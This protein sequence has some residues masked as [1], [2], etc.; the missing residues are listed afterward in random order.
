MNPP[1]RQNLY[2]AVAL[3]GIMLTIAVL[4][5]GEI[6][7]KL[8][9]RSSNSVTRS[10]SETAETRQTTSRASFATGSYEELGIVSEFQATEEEFLH[11][12]CKGPQIYEDWIEA[13]QMRLP[14]NYLYRGGP[15]KLWE[16]PPKKITGPETLRAKHEDCE[17][18]LPNTHAFVLF[19]A[20][21]SNP[22]H[23]IAEFIRPMM[24]M[25]SICLKDHPKHHSEE[26]YVLA[27]MEGLKTP[28]WH[29]TIFSSLLTW[30]AGSY[31]RVWVAAS[32]KDAGKWQFL[33][34]SLVP[35]T[36]AN[37]ESSK[38][39]FAEHSFLRS[40]TNGPWSMHGVPKSLRNLK[41][42]TTGT[43]WPFTVPLERTATRNMKILES[44]AE[45]VKQLGDTKDSP[46]ETFISRYLPLKS[47]TARVGTSV[48]QAL[49]QSMPTR[50]NEAPQE[51]TSIEALGEAVRARM[52]RENRKL[53]V[54]IY[55]RADEPTAKLP[56]AWVNAD[57]TVSALNKIPSAHDLMEIDHIHTMPIAP[58]EQAEKYTA[59]VLICPHG[60]HLGNLIFSSNTLL[61]EGV[62]SQNFSG[63]RWYYW[64]RI[65]LGH[66]IHPV[67]MLHVNGQGSG[68]TVDPA[69]VI[70]PLSAL[71]NVDTH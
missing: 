49:F 27:V 40:K 31:D 29:R 4:R 52:Q 50:Y 26:F 16:P 41:R 32:D 44:H 7:S 37:G 35:R 5:E 2:A 14:N 28:S 55:D 9:A 22:V 17:D 21:Q 11:S 33:N 39:C 51:W 46:E 69:L 38:Q 1:I 47:A 66:L 65:A 71:L 60:G 3:A 25:A 20:R 57:E 12:F 42:D 15:L 45:R 23:L 19:F 43:R 54:L 10:K 62:P 18:V 30:I 70:A 68:L 67:K 61:I 24:T 53:R 6:H 63:Q 36:Q 48:M 56:R 34:G 8:R 64:T 58:S 59:D 13:E